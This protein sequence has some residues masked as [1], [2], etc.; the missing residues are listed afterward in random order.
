VVARSTGFK[1]PQHSLGRRCGFIDFLCIRVSVCKLGTLCI[2]YSFL[3]SNNLSL[4]RYSVFLLLFFSFLLA[5]LSDA[6]SR[7]VERRRLLIA[8]FFNNKVEVCVEGGWLVKVPNLA[9]VHPGA[10]IGTL[11]L[12]DVSLRYI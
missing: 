7:P 9:L 5:S 11:L 6:I 3:L 12:F 8:E 1:G 4:A 10:E 2:D